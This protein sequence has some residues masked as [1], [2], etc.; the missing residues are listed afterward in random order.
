MKRRL[1]TISACGALAV[2]VAF[3]AAAGSQAQ[4]PGAARYTADG[5]LEFPKDYRTWIYLSTGLDMS[6]LPLPASMMGHHM[7]DSVFVDPAS[8]AAFQKT[9]TWPDGA[10]F[11]LEVRGAQDKGSINK[12]GQYQT[13]TVMGRET[14]VK[15]KRF[16]SGWAF[17]PFGTGEGPAA[18]L[19]QASDCNKCHEAHGAVDTTMVQFYPTLLPI[20]EAKKTFSAA[21]LAEEK[22][23]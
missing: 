13:T 11:V 15:D 19:P 4:A 7:F 5:K 16:A 22:A 17:F 23:R 1:L 3:L 8:Y 18:A 20:A 2:A 9:G 10:V 14:H 21:Y 6:Y 12:S